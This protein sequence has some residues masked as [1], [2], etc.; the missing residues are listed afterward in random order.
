MANILF[1]EDQQE[2]IRRVG[3]GLERRG[4]QVSVVG[5]GKKAISA[6]KSRRFDVIVLDIVL[7]AGVGWDIDLKEL[8]RQAY[9]QE[10]DE[11]PDRLMESRMGVLIIHTIINEEI[12][13]PVILLSA[14]ITKEVREEL[15]KL[16]EKGLR[17]AA[18]LNKPAGYSDIIEAIQSALAK[19]PMETEE[20][21]A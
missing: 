4:H 2:V 9:G 7:P 6:L 21:P 10:A 11:L 16:E 13:T 5:S 17:T 1:V 20:T 15:E 18:V 12:K 19:Q 3:R 14:Y 8:Y